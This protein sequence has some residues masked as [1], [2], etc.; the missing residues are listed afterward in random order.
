MSNT[1]PVL[2]SDHFENSLHVRDSIASGMKFILN[3]TPRTN[4]S[5]GRHGVCKGKTFKGSGLE[6]DEYPFGSSREGGL[7]NF[8]RG[9]VSLR[10][11][12]M[13]VNSAAGTRLQQFYRECGVVDN[14]PIKG[15]FG[16]ITNLAST[17][18]RSEC[19]G[20]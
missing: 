11:I 6:C 20:K 15:V 7:Q 9:Q 2:G 14:D 3:K 19:P 8:N 12:S 4:W 10:P 16:V 5:P 1:H 17:I 13:S 18:T